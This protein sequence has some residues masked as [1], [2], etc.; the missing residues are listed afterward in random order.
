MALPNKLFEYLHAGLPLVVTDLRELGRFVC[1]HGLGETFRSGNPAELAASAE[2]A[3]ANPQ[4]YRRAA[5]D[6]A[7]RAEHSWEHQERVLV[8]VYGE[9]VGAPPGRDGGP[10]RS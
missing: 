6:P 4:P 1:E 8:A 7:L 10:G 3:F 5:A 2:K 9:L